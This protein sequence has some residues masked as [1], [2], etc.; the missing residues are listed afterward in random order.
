MAGSATLTTVLSMNAML[1]PRIVAARIQTLACSAHGISSPPDRS[2]AS[3]QGVLMQAPVAV[4]VSSGLN[5]H[6]ALGIRERLE[7]TEQ[8]I[9]SGTQVPAT[10][11]LKNG[12]RRRNRIR[13]GA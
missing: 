13:T 2:T 12:E 4:Y 1:D 8:R 5:G 10:K 6:R 9:L 11:A 3:S 7:V